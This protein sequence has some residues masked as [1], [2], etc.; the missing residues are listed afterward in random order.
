MRLQWMPRNWNKSKRKSRRTFRLLT[1]SS[2]SRRNHKNKKIILPFT[3]TISKMNKTNIKWRTSTFKNV[4]I[5]PYSHQST[6]YSHQSPRI[7]T[8]STRIKANSTASKISNRNR[9]CPNKTLLFKINCKLKLNPKRQKP[10]GKNLLR[11]L[12]SPKALR[13]PANLRKIYKPRTSLMRREFRAVK[14]KSR[15]K[16][17]W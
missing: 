14:V 6:R 7:K 16:V 1:I 9:N 8:N 17:K 10:R 3:K 4:K 15:N 13:R 12:T 2:G 11:N 5:G